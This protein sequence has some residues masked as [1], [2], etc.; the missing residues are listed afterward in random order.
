MK[1]LLFLPVAAA[2][3]LL[4]A[5]SLE[6]YHMGGLKPATMQEL[7]TFSVEMFANHSTQPT[8]GVLLTTAVTDSLQRDGTYRLASSGKAD[9]TVSGEITHLSRE[10]LLTDPNDTYLSREVG[11][12]VHVRYTVRNNRTGAVIMQRDVSGQGSYFTDAGNQQSAVDSALSYA[13]RNA[14]EELTND[15][16]TP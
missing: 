7:S 14:A 10:S 2:A 3:L 11:L 13:A 1:R 8:A 12:T 9:F 5:C 6:L 16:T 15:L 4:S